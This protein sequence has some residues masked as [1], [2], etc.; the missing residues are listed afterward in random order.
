MFNA[1]FIMKKNC[2]HPFLAML[3]SAF[4]IAGAAMMTSCTNEDAI[5]PGNGGEIRLLTVTPNTISAL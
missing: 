4:G 3:V 5:A 2:Y 1:P